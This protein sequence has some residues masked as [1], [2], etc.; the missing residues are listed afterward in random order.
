MPKGNSVH[1]NI[2]SIHSPSQPTTGHWAQVQTKP[3]QNNAAKGAGRPSKSNLSSPLLSSLSGPC[4]ACR[5]NRARRH[6]AA[7]STVNGKTVNE[8]MPSGIPPV[9]CHSIIK[10]IPTNA[11][12]NPDDTKSAIESNIAPCAPCA[13]IA[14][15]TAPSNT[16][17]NCPN[18]QTTSNQIK[19]ATRRLSSPK[20]SIHASNQPKEA[21]HSAGAQP[22]SNSDAA[23]QH[24]NAP[25]PRL[26]RVKALA[27][28]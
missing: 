28:Q 1:P 2:P 14:R 16:S 10:A 5:E 17:H 11:G 18:I 15:A 4:T 19:P 26:M 20:S 21:S 25:D 8:A 3:A 7:I 13:P 6:A 24:T 9:A 12:A 27:G 23:H 22:K